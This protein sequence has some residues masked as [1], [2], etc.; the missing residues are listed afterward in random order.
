VHQNTLP[1]GH[2]VDLGPNWIHGT[3]HNPVVDLA[4]KTNTATYSWD[5]ES[6]NLFDGNGILVSNAAE[7]SSW[8]WGTIM[9][10]FKCSE[11]HSAT[12]DPEKSLWDFFLEKTAETSI[13]AEG[14]EKTNL[15]LQVA[16]MWGAFV[17]QHIT[18]QSLK[19]FWLEE[20][21]DGGKIFFV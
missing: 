8:F 1:N 15:M 12:I 4:K 7:I 20:V 14:K 10:A 5:T 9:E 18:C 21:I 3:D 11:E 6:D 2:V 16:E 13:T 17:G 19:F